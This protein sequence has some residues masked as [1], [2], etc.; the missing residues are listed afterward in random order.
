M[1]VIVRSL[2]VLFVA[3]SIANAELTAE[4]ISVDGA[5]SGAVEGDLTEA[6][7]IDKLTAHGP[8]DGLAHRH[9]PALVPLRSRR[10]ARR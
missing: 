8:I 7:F 6:G 1:R 3:S 2:F 10:G 9:D 5:G 4:Y